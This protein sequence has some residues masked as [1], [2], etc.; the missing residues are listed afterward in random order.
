MKLTKEAVGRWMRERKLAGDRRAGSWPGELALRR[1]AE[2]VKRS[3]PIVVAPPVIAIAMTPLAWLIPDWTRPF[4]LGVILSSGIW[5]SI[6]EVGT[7]SGE[8]PARAGQLAERWTARELRRLRR[9]G[10]FLVNELIYREWDI[11]HVIVGPGGVLAF[12]TKYS[13]SGWGKSSYTDDLLSQA[14]QRAA[15][16]AKDV[17]LVSGKAILPRELVQSIVVL[18][19]GGYDQNRPAPVDGVRVLPGPQ[20]RETLASLPQDGLNDDAVA[21]IYSKIDK[22]I[23]SRDKADLKRQGPRR[24]SLSEWFTFSAGLLFVAACGFFAEQ[25]VLHLIGWRWF[26]PVGAAFMLPIWAVHHLSQAR[27]W[28]IAWL[29]G[30]QTITAVFLVAYLATEIQRIS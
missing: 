25:Q 15:D 13:S 24:R 20:L 1:R 3:W 8:A 19:G 14:A 12:Q 21:A 29:I 6:Y 26:I 10:W 23:A 22:H 18:W 28:W 2:F 5:F 30:S 7:T 27:A 9:R 16:S 11:D 4:A 17:W